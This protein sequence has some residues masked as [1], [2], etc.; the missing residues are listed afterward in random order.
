MEQS[1]KEQM[2]GKIELDKSTNQLSLDHK[3]T[4]LKNKQRELKDVE[5]AIKANKE[6]VVRL[7]K[8][9]ELFKKIGQIVIDNFGKVKP[10]FKFEEQPAY[11]ELMKEKQAVDNERNIAQITDN[12]RQ[13]ETMIK[14]ME[15][16]L[17]T[18]K[19]GIIINEQMIEDLKEEIKNG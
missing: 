17:I 14:K 4:D 6:E 15:E 12:V 5:Y 11:I 10:E 13:A 8:D 9:I 16:N 2:E 19:S 7:N 1:L 3:E 18:L